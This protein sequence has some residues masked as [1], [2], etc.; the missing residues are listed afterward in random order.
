M[1]AREDLEMVFAMGFDGANWVVLAP[2]ALAH[3]VT[4][5]WCAW[6]D[7]QLLRSHIRVCG[8]AVELRD[9][10]TESPERLPLPGAL[11]VAGLPVAEQ[12]GHI[13]TTRRRR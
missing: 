8:R 4:E 13:G 9:P 10:V 3:P 7:T 12:C 6:I 1:T 5:I 11:G 2:R